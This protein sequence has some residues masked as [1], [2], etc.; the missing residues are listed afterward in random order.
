MKPHPPASARPFYRRVAILATI[1][2]AA[3]YPV[4]ESLVAALLVDRDLARLLQHL[5]APDRDLLAQ[6]LLAMTVILALGLLLDSIHRRRST[7][8]QLRTVTSDLRTSAATARLAERVFE[9]ALEGIVVTDPDGTIV[10]VNP[11]FSAITGYS[12]EEAIG[13]NPRMLRSERHDTSF[14]ERMW[15]ALLGKGQWSGEIWNRKKSGEAYPEW[16]NISA[17][18]DE[19]GRTTNFVAVFHDMSD[20]KRDHLAIQHLAQHDPLTGLPNRSLLDDRLQMALAQAR[21]KSAML[22]VVFVDLDD[23][24]EVN[25]THGHSTGDQLLQHV[26]LVLRG[27]VR[28]EDTVARFGGDEFVLLLTGLGDTFGAVRAVHCAQQA[29]AEPLEIAGR[30]LEV[31]ASFGMTF[32]PAD[33]ASADIL[34]R[35]AD[36]AMYRAKELGPGGLQLFVPDMNRRLE[37]R[38]ELERQL[39]AALAADRFRVA[40]QPRFEAGSGLIVGAEALVR[41][42]IDSA[43]DRLPATFLPLAEETGLVVPV[44]E[45][46]IRQ[47]TRLLR[48]WRD[49]GHLELFVAVNLSRRQLADGS[50]AA[51]LSSAISEAGVPANRVRLEIAC[52]DLMNAVEDQRHTLEQLHGLGFEI[53]VD[54]V[55]IEALSLAALRR[56]PVSTVVL[57]RTLVDSLPSSRDAGAIVRAVLAVSREL[58]LRVAAVGVSSPQQLEL[59]RD[60]SCHELQGY[61]LSAPLT[62]DE[63]LAYLAESAA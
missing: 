45:H 63:L 28:D 3:V 17:I 5:W 33:G 6:R 52:A 40:Y 49:A 24:K 39:R 59:L 35:N 9:N 16:L 51:T 15:S 23:F 37:E 42:S 21:R 38:L 43:A 58:G 27:C 2:A 53:A 44:G 29:L 25:D 61:L 41:W 57:S 36:L 46:V 31:T 7:E 10:M 22:A 14:Y 30:R 12:A 19:H 54:D 50:L 60:A 26:A 11:A 55:G 56:L 18:R 1:A 13:Q 4:L 48:A 47:A 20:I 8:R 32:Y 34:L 62:G